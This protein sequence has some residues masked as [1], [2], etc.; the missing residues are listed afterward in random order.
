MSELK[1]FDG[2]NWIPV[3]QPNPLY[4]KAI[5]NDMVYPI[6][7]QY[8][9]HT[10]DRNPALILGVGTWVAIEG[11]VIVGLDPGDADF[12]TAGET[13][14]TKTETLSISQVP[15]VQG[16]VQA[17]SARSAWWSPGG[18]FSG[19][20]MQST[21]SPPSGAVGGANSVNMMRF[22]NGGGGGSHNNLQPYEV[23]YVWKRTA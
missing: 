15:N 5:I 12:D 2:V 8:V 20:T 3:G 11:R 23:A 19:S 17:H 16:T 22:N 4:A 6:G 13:G 10:D 1:Y 18:A 9:N 21:Y 14:G 7:S